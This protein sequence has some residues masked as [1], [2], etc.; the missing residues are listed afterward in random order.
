[1]ALPSKITSAAYGLEAYV[2]RKTTV[3]DEV[4]SPR[5]A[6]NFLAILGW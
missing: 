4:S 1:M 2:G 3:M 5:P 6:E